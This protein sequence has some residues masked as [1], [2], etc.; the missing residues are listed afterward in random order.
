MRSLWS[1]LDLRTLLDTTGGILPVKKLQGCVVL[2][3]DYGSPAFLSA[4]LVDPITAE[5]SPIN[6]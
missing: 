6:P 1:S 4:F 2:L 3:D 5:W